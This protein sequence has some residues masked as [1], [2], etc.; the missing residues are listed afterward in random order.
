VQLRRTQD[1]TAHIDAL[2]ARHGGRV[3]LD[4]V[5]G[6]LDRRLRRTWA[7]GVKVHRAWTWEAADRRDPAWWPQG[8]AVAPDS[9][10][11]VA[12]SWYHKG[13]GSRV[14]VLDLDRRRYRHV[15]LVRADEDGDHQPLAVH[16]GGLAWHGPWLHVAATRSG[17]WT[18]HVDDVVR[19]RDGYVWPARF[20]HRPVDGDLRFSFLSVDVTTTPHELVV[21][22]Y[23]S[24][25]QTRRVA[26]FPI[27]PAT[28]LPGLVGSIS[29]HGVV[30]AQ[31]MVR[32]DG[33]LHATASHGPWRPGTVWS[34]EPGAYRRRRWAAPM[35][36]E[37][38][39]HDPRTDLIWT[40]TEHPRRR[41]VVAMRRSRVV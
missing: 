37:D 9:P 26:V 5:R 36:P 35:G 25:S 20:A 2:A 15:E 39:A 1:Q 17:F 30:R 38:L 16:A 19:T 7:P 18:C 23:G 34:G 24:A 4:G 12:V 8:V 32:I 27:D 6:D 29:D 41:W 10:V 14:S 28:L 33:E 13:G 22:E 3:G 21:G 11:L 31:G 40:V